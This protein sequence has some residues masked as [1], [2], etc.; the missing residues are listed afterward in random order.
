[1]H[2]KTNHNIINYPNLKIIYISFIINNNNKSNI[3][4]FRLL[5]DININEINISNIFLRCMNQ[6][7]VYFLRKLNHPNI[8]K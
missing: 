8:I 1:M 4:K 6:S 2:L 5:I 3:N 7:E